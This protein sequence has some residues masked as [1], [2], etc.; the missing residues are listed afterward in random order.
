MIEIVDFW[1]QQFEEF[2]PTLVINCGDV[3]DRF[4]SKYNI[5]YR[6]LAGSRVMNLHQWAHSERWE[7]PRIREFFDAIEEVVSPVNLDR[8]YVSNAYYVNNFEARNRFIPLMKET[9]Y[10]VLRNLYWRAKGY[11]KASGY[12]LGD[13]I[14]YIWRRRGALQKLS[15]D[16]VC[17]LRD[18]QGSMFVF[19]PLHTEP[20]AAL[21]G[22]SP[23]WTFQLEAIISLSR[24]LPAGV[25]LAVKETQP[26]L[27]RRP[28]DFYDQISE[29]KNV[30]FLNINERG[31]DVVHA[32]AAVATIT[33]TAGFEAAV[34]GKPVISFGKY[35]QYNFLDHVHVVDEYA[36]LRDAIESA[37]G[38]RNVWKAQCDG[39]RFLLATKRASFD[40]AGYNFMRPQAVTEEMTAPLLKSLEES[41]QKL[42]SRAI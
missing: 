34:S 1:S 14:R 21:Q 11:Q 6:V 23:E 27:G 39:A 41:L 4:A 32:A 19:Y 13:Q 15:K 17:S 5:P 9:A 31:V 7:N 24:E 3:A 38:E 35:N 10:L 16:R 22:L 42:E 30:R 18:L 29:L 40:L 25:L 37:L 8:P 26:A 20:E 36:S 28:R 33:G 12:Y 2:K